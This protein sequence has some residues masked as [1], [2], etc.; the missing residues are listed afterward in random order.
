MSLGFIT[1]GLAGS[2]AKI[3]QVALLA[4]V[5]DLVC[6]MSVGFRLRRSNAG[7]EKLRLPLACYTSATVAH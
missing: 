5:A 4:S 3:S 1:R 6:Y 7:L 2:S